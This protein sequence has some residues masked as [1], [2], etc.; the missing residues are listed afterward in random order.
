MLAR[1]DEYAIAPMSASQAYA[2]ACCSLSERK[3]T[4]GS[5]LGGSKLRI[6]TATSEHM[7]RNLKPDRADTMVPTAIGVCPTEPGMS[8]S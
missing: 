3:E 8:S 4:E 7:N 1:L 6:A 2:L 5:A